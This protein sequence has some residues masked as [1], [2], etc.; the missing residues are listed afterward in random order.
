[1]RLF[2]PIYFLTIFGALL[3]KAVIYFNIIMYE[4]VIDTREVANVLSAFQEAFDTSLV[5][6]TL[7]VGDIHIRYN[8]QPVIVIE[9][10]TINDLA[11]SL[12][13]RYHEQKARLM[14]LKC[15][16]IYMIEEPYSQLNKTYHH[17]FTEE[18]YKGIILNTIVR[19]NMHVI[20]T[21]D[22]NDTIGIIKDMLKRLPKYVKELV[23]KQKDGTVGGTVGDTS[24]ELKY[25]SMVDVKKRDH[26]TPLVCYI[27][28]LKMV[29][30]VST[31]IAKTIAAKY[32]TMR[33]LI[34]ELDVGGAEIIAK[35]MVDGGSRHIGKV[36]ANRLVEYLGVKN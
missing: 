5:R 20:T 22:L 9:R 35:M 3:K 2:C 25:A 24:A 27:N 33:E 23:E 16:V 18:T 13:D 36:V 14:G 32:G 6:E 12:K 30:S 15:R 21:T 7:N 29:P 11:S 1:M 28:Q 19:D 10:K 31:A 8:G 26:N 17:E 34:E 4:V